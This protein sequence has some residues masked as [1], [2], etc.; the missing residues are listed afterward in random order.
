MEQRMKA[1]IGCAMKRAECDLVVKGGG[2]FNVFTGE[3]ERA[4]LAVKD[5]VIVG[6]GEGYSAKEEY[7]ASGKVL[8]PGLCDAHMH[9]ESSMLTPEQF[10]SLAVPHG[11]SL[12]VADPHELV[13]VCGVEGAEYV[14]EAFS[15]LRSG[16][17]PL[18]VLLQLPSCVPATPFETSG[19]RLDARATAEELA[20]PG[21]FGLGEMMNYPGVLAADG[22]T[23]GK[24]AAARRLGKIADGH[25]P[26]ITGDA[27]NAYL[28][29]GIATDHESLSSA[30]IAE[31]I[32]RGMYVQI[33]CGSSANNA[34][35]CAPLMTT[36][37]FTRFLLCTDDRHAAD[38]MER[39]HIDEA[40]RQLISLGV[41]PLWAIR[42]A[43]MNVAEC[44]GLRGRGALAP[45][46]AAD[47]A[48]VDSVEGMHVCA[49]WKKG[50]LVAEG[51]KPLFAAQAYL[52]AAVR[53]TVHV[54]EVTADSFRM[55]IPS[56]RARAIRVLPN[57]LVTEAVTVSVGQGAG[58]VALADGLCKLAVVERHFASGNI[59]L[60]LLKDYGFHGGAMGLSVAHDSHNL[61]VL[62]DDNAAMARVVQLLKE[63][64]GGM[65][66]VGEREEV[67][68]LDVAGLMS[69]APAAEVA[70]RSAHMSRLA[71]GMGVKEGY[72]PF[73]TL[74]FLALPVIP[75]IKLT[76]RG[77]FDVDAFCFV[78]VEAER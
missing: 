36:E 63:A 67:F 58:D 68:P 69:S 77:L 21:F 47:M 46:Y 66:L 65:A 75:H 3:T 62:G 72:D 76:D 25:A 2:I 11:T 43:T 49:V 53:G 71:R 10:A 31:K 16:D 29:A 17:P 73:M 61:V 42:T 57:E 35:V 1:W 19:A 15:R 44:Y 51:G 45:G 55:N 70:A 40:V 4:D 48:A 9:V 37:N 27:L 41:P 8:I 12:I 24:L 6:I 52:P 13:N 18:D 32:A 60:A 28:C 22:D 14:R 33:R 20:K 64:G 74:A 34:A 78:S 56:G 23:L 54:G 7:D 38:L 59:G 50:A 30:E 5:G 39:G 26:G